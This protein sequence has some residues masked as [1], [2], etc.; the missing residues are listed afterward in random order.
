MI[1]FERARMRENTANAQP[2]HERRV[3]VRIKGKAASLPS[4]FIAGRTVIRSGWWLKVARIKDE[5]LIEARPMDDPESFLAELRDSNLSADVF[6]FSQSVSDSTPRYGYY[7]EWDNLAVIR[8]TAF[9]D[10]WLQ[11]PDS[12]QRAIRKAMRVGVVTREVALDDE[13]V[14]GIRTIYDESPVRQG[15]VFWHYRKD[16]QAVKA[17][18]ST[19]SDRNLFIGAYYGSELIGFVRIIRVGR[20][21]EIIQILSKKAHQDKRPTNA[22]IAKAVELCV[23]RGM[24]HLVYCNY[25]Y[26]DPRS[27]LTEFKRRNRFEQVLVP[28][29]Y[30]PLTWK[31]NVMLKLRLHHGVK[32][33]MPHLGIRIFLRSRSWFV[34]RIV[35]PLKTTDHRKGS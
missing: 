5:E 15:R 1:S 23:E 28:R 24:S 3:E 9:S 8:L 34:E 11:L 32:S 20:V 35:A 12:V 33:L 21:A 16:F 2:Q 10:W 27:S 25:V 19:Y 29:Y 6:T 31:G 14:E 7:H 26:R 22:L 18:N 17:E 30:V 4:A 13:L